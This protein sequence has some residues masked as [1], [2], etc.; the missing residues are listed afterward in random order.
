MWCGWM[1]ERDWT[2]EGCKGKTFAAKPSVGYEGIEWTEGECPGWAVQQP[3]IAEIG[4]AFTAF[5]AG[6]L[7]V[8]FPEITNV[9]AEGLL[10]LKRAVAIYDRVATQ[11]QAAKETQGG[12]R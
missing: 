2:G 3:A 5:E 12:G 9:M 1:D 8:M 10:E 6:A 11:V 4:D 7:A